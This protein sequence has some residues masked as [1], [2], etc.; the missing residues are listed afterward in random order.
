MKLCFAIL[1]LAA[2]GLDPR[3]PGNTHVAHTALN[4][5]AKHAG[6]IVPPLENVKSDKKFFGPPFPADYPHD[7]QPPSSRR[8][9]EKGQPYPKVQ[10]QGFFDKDYVKDE[11]GDGGE[12]KAQMDYDTA[13][14]KIDRTKQQR[15]HAEKN[16][17]EEHRHVDE[18]AAKYEEK[19]EKEDKAKEAAQE[20]ARRAQEERDRAAEASRHVREKEAENEAK[21]RAAEEEQR[22]A[23]RAAER[24]EEA[25][26]NLEKKVEEAKDAL[27]KERE[28]FKDCQHELDEAKAHVERLTK[29]KD[30]LVKSQ[31][32][33]STLVVKEQR[34]LEEQK[35]LLQ[36]ER[37]KFNALEAKRTA[38]LARLMAARNETQSAQK[39]LDEQKAEH[40]AAEQKAKQEE[41]ELKDAEKEL[42]EARTQL[43]KQRGPNALPPGEEQPTEKPVKSRAACVGAGEILTAVLLFM[44][45]AS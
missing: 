42:S 3:T 24:R 5:M 12:W 4:K 37:S 30:N 13:R 40:K 38:A 28:S 41:K 22:D 2:H 10:E 34:M 20:T 11:N 16:A 8:M 44:S 36:E 19:K 27:D 31:Q 15:K 18:A 9:F 1:T 33:E 7:Q 26:K 25:R 45:L 43:R 29:E 6:R 35:R 23:K 14:T 21:V 39:E 32:D 17:E